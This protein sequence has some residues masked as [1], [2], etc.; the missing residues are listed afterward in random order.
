MSRIAKLCAAVMIMAGLPLAAQIVISGQVNYQG[1]NV[2]YAPIQVCSVTSTGA[3]C[4]PTAAIYYD[5]TL[6]SPAPNPTTADSFGNYTF[7]AANLPTPGFYIVQVTPV[8]GTIW[9]YVV[10]GVGTGNGCL[11]G[12]TLANG[13]T[14]ATT[15]TGA[16]N[17]I[18][19]P[20]GTITGPVN[21][22][23]SDS[24]GVGQAVVGSSS[25]SL[26]GTASPLPYDLPQ[27]C[28][29]S[30]YILQPKTLMNSVGWTNG[31]KYLT[32]VC[33]SGD[34]PTVTATTGT[35][36]L[37]AA[38]Y[39]YV[40]VEWTFASGPNLVSLEAF[41]PLTLTGEIAVGPPLA[42]VPAGAVNMRVFVAISSGQEQ[43]QGTVSAGSTLTISAPLVSGV[44]PAMVP[45]PPDGLSS[46]YGYAGSL[47]V[48]LGPSTGAAATSTYGTTLLGSGAG[49]NLVSGDQDTFLGW[50]AGWLSTNAAHTTSVGVGAGSH[51]TG[52]IYNVFIGTDDCLFCTSGDDNTF[53][54]SGTGVNNTASLN[55]F[56]GEDVAP[57]NTTGGGNTFAGALAA[58]NNTTGFDNTIL[59]E[60]AGGQNTTGFLDVFIG[61]ATGFGNTTG[62]FNS[63][64]GEG[65]FFQGPLTGFANTGGGYQSGLMLTTGSHNSFYGAF[66]GFGTTT[67]S[68]NAFLGDS[69]GTINSTQ[70][71]SVMLGASAG[72][73]AQGGSSTFLGAY[74]GEGAFYIPPPATP[75]GTATYQPIVGLSSGTIY[76]VLEGYDNTLAYHSQHSSEAS[77]TVNGTTTNVCVWTNTAIP[78]AT[79]CY[80]FVGASGAENTYF[81]VPCDGEEFFQT[82]ATGA[83]GSPDGSNNT[84][85]ANTGSGNVYV[86]EAT[87]KSNTTGYSNTIVGTQSFLANTTGYDNT[88]IG[89]Q[90]C[91]NEVSSYA[92]LCGGWEAGLAA[93]GTHDD[94]FL[95]SAS[96][97][98]STRTVS[99]GAM[100]DCTSTPTILD[101]ATANFQTI[102]VHGPIS[103]AGAGA[104]GTALT[105]NIYSLNSSTEVV[106]TNGCST[107]VTGATVSITTP[108]TGADNT[109]TGSQSGA[110]NMSGGG[111]TFNGA[112]AGS[113]NTTGI[114]NTFV[115]NGAGSTNTT[116]NTNTAIGQG[117]ALA[118]A[119]DTDE[120]VIGR[121]V[122]GNG[123]HTATIGTSTTNA[124]YLKGVIVQGVGTNV[125][126]AS[127]IAPVAPLTHITGTTTISTITLPVSGFT[128]C[129]RLIPDGLWSTTTGGNIALGSTA[130]VGKV[131]EECY[132]GTSW[133]PSY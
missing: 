12:N 67:G 13:C 127:T 50:H 15:Q 36:T 133:Y 83:S 86:G 8:A 5:Y 16:F 88:A 7:Y 132:D 38:P 33:G 131:L 89:Y 62:F 72:Q 121:G 28:T 114:D 103:V 122:T 39:Y 97:T 34:L 79:N 112:Y 17:N 130:V 90:T 54:G 98:G 109:F 117:T 45:C 102:D 26:C 107:T 84:G 25:P 46:Q 21:F 68:S 126:S 60:V 48:F 47:N 55:T 93:Y 18:V 2:P 110:A 1:T 82:T 77:C 42:G 56:L 52:G 40:Q 119:T 22:T 57:N 91:N 30:L 61:R 104:G 14:G 100:S 125:A 66:G 94:V 23:G 69:A 11:G 76:A 29:M 111:N 81:A 58:V 80:L 3:P 85:P 129:I 105:A 43:L 19:A 64:Y 120:I 59:G 44:V 20:G 96:G 95:G 63:T 75:T 51:M 32:A 24:T 118:G 92:L 73:N 49:Q 37:P 101:S 65:S 53:V 4:T 116:G 99:D 27:A 41:Q 108:D 6:S 9:S 106:L 123:S 71:N 70:S 128:G 10:G 74:A 78:N 31:G 35:G 124:T 113:A 115:G 87:G